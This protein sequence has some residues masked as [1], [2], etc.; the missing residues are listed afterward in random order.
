MAIAWSQVTPSLIRT[1]DTNTINTPAAA[2]MR[3]GTAAH[4][5]KNDPSRQIAAAAVAIVSGS[6]WLPRPAATAAI[7][8]K[9]TATSLGNIEGR[10]PIRR[11]VVFHKTAVM[12]APANAQPAQM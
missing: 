9:A 5:V 8:S 3:P 7:P 11:D 2:T 4:H 12:A 1:Y 10:T 6:G